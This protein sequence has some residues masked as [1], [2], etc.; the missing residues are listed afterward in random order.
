MM[1]PK[2]SMSTI[3]A[4]NAYQI[5]SLLTHHSAKIQIDIAYCR[6]DILIVNQE[7][8]LIKPKLQKLTVNSVKKEKLC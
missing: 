5:I 7:I 6:V 3:N 2:V 4:N 8:S 1:I